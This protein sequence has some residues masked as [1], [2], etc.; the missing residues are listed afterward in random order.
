VALAVTRAGRP[1]FLSAIPDLARWT[2]K[3]KAEANKVFQ[4][5]YGSSEANYLRLMQRHE[6]LRAA[7]LKMGTRKQ[8]QSQPT[9]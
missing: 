9:G 2:K 8:P 7:F 3:A 5:K 4:A 1:D 6:R